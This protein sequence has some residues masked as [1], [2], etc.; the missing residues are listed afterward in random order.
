MNGESG[1]KMIRTG[2]EGR[3]VQRVTRKRKEDKEERRMRNFFFFNY[4]LA[5]KAGLHFMF[6]FLIRLLFTTY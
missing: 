6:F 2:R 1:T 4:L 5:L 3:M